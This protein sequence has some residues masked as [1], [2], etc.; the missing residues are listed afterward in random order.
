MKIAAFALWIFSGVLLTDTLLEARSGHVEVSA[1]SRSGKVYTADRDMKPEEFQQLMN[2]QWVRAMLPAALGWIL[3][4][5]Q[6]RWD[7]LDPL[8]SNS[9][10]E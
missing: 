2:F 8:S 1:I 7:T 3:F 9:Q 4:S 10:S 5:L 6:R